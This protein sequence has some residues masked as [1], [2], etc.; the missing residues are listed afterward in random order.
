[1]KTLSASERLKLIAS[2][3]SAKKASDRSD[4]SD[5]IRMA[6]ERNPK[7]YHGSPKK[8]DILSSNATG[9]WSGE[10]GKG[11]FVTP[12][13]GIAANFVVNRP[14]LVKRIERRLRE[15]VGDVHFRYDQW[16][17]STEE[18]QELPKQVD[19]RTDVEGFKPIHGRAKGYLY[20]VDSDKY[21]ERHMFSKNPNSDVGFLL[22]GDMVP[23]KRERVSVRYTLHPKD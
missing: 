7:V 18:L 13:K 16:D 2:L 12:Y 1:M 15:R 19:V 11:V 4:I 23:D 5:A 22:N 8:L 21:P 17:K 6:L 3:S 14:D 10:K 9:E 20:S